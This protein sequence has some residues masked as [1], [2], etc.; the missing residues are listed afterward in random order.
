MPRKPSPIN[1]E[2]EE[3]TNIIDLSN[4]KNETEV[5]N[6]TRMLAAVLNYLTDD[7]LEEMDIE[8]LLDETKGL[9]EWWN[10][11]QEGNR[12]EIEEEIKKSLGELSLKD[13]KRIRE[14]ITEKQ[15]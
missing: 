11:Y 13:L 12:K 7:D 8:Y 1:E 14:Q 4:K 6:L 10:Q 15:E 5:D 2:D 3:V 9:R